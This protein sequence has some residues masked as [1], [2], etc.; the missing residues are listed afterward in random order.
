MESLTGEVIV[1]LIAALGFGSSAIHYSAFATSKAKINYRKE[2][3][4]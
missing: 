4:D 3:I 1:M 2:K